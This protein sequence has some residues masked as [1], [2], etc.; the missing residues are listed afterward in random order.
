VPDTPLFGP[1]SYKPKLRSEYI[2]LSNALHQTIPMMWLVLEIKQ[3]MQLPMQTIPKVQ[4]TL[5]KDNA[6][7][8][9]LANV[10]KM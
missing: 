1:P 10:P 5:L 7:A 3:K 6:G 9:E 8:V 2:S 4:C